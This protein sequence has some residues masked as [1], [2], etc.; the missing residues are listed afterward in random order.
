MVFNNYQLVSIACALSK[1]F[2]KAMYNRHLTYYVTGQTHNCSWKLR[3]YNWG[4]SGI[5][6][7]LDTNNHQI[8]FAKVI[9]QID[10]NLLHTM[11]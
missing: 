11:A 4:V 1:F 9:R 8:L 3:I 2:E 5:P 7:G 6:K 10:I